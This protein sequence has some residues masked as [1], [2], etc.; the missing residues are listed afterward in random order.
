MSCILSSLVAKGVG[1]LPTEYK[2]HAV[3]G[4]VLAI[5]I[6]TGRGGD[7]PC[8]AVVDKNWDRL[9]QF[10]CFKPDGIGL[11]GLNG[12]TAIN[13]TTGHRRACRAGPV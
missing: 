6:I 13:F 1:S 3:N 5:D 7:C 2:F 8:Y 10:G 9:D 12:C 11:T 4:E